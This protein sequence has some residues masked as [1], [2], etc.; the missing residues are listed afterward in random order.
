METVYLSGYGGSSYILRS[1]LRG[2]ET[3]NWEFLYSEVG[4]SDPTYE[5]WKL[6]Y[7]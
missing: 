5:A 7:C 2:M 3:E 4:N 1:Y 6:P